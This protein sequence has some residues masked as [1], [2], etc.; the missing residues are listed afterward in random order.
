MRSPLRAFLAP[1]LLLLSFGAAA[2]SFP[3]LDQLEAKLKLT[4]AQKAQYDR[5]VVAT[6]RALIGMGL[7]AA[8]IKDDVTKE[9]AKDV[10]DFGAL[11]RHQNE[12][13]ERQ[14]PLFRDASREWERLFK[15]LDERQLKIAKAWVHDNLGRYFR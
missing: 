12:F 15:Q 14:A 6:K 3:E 2:Q 5:V 13:F 4:P 1:L 8:Q 9:L 11:V 7:A 10:P